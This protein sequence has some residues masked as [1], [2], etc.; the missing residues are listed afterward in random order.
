MHNTS[1]V[2]LLLIGVLFNTLFSGLATA[3]QIQVVSVN[4]NGFG[5][6]ESEA[7]LDAVVNGIAQVNGEA[8]ASSVRIA[9]KAFSS[10]DNKAKS[11]SLTRSIDEDISRETKGVVQSWQKIS[12]EKSSTGDFDALVTVNVFVLKK[13]EQLKRIKLAVVPSQ[14]SEPK[15]T[16]SLAD[17][18]ARNLTTSRKFALMDRK[19]ST[20]IES[21]L[22]RIAKGGSAEDSVRLSAEVAPDFIAVVSVNMT[23]R[24]DGTPTAFG[25]LEVIDYSTRQVKL[26]EKRNIPLKQG[27]D[28]SNVRRIAMIGRELSRAVVQAVFPPIVLGED[29]G[30]ITIAQGSDFFSIGDQLVIKKMGAI[31]RD[32]H[33][34]EYLGQDHID[35]GIAVVSYV[36]SRIARAKLSNRTNFDPNLL[37]NQKY[38]VWRTGETE[39]DLFGG[40]IVSRD[41]GA[42]APTAKKEK[43]MFS[44]GDID[45]D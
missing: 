19:Y 15:Q 2:W 38:Q 23:T 25:S 11:P 14:G 35:V 8:I 18:V 33:T 9:S 28:T 30:F 12:A 17:E 27:D 34:S 36:D 21:Q 10:S 29:S 37:A 26:S 20:E 16:L 31:L 39:R 22:S 43:T 5:R 4:S 41:K 40:A 44:T 42:S 7:L 3:Q 45:E 6:T 24:P 32:P 13:S 1:R